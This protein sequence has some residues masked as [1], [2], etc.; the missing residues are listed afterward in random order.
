MCLCMYVC[1]YT[2][3]QGG[4]C[5]AFTE[6]EYTCY[7]FDVDAPF[8]AASLD[9][10]LHCFRAPLLASSAV[11]REVKAIHNEFNIAKIE[12]ANRYQLVTS[13]S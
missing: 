5:N 4:S 10:F 2:C 3:V 7:Q 6:G 8:L 9:I 12:D 13:S 1:I 11:D